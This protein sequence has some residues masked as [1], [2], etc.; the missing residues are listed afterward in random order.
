[1]MTT[2]MKWHEESRPKDENLRDP[3]DYE[4]WKTLVTCYH[5]YFLT[6]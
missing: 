3:L 1:M 4:C 6:L 2:F 5:D